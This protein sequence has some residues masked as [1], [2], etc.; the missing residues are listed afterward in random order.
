MPDATSLSRMMVYFSG[1][2]LFK[3]DLIFFCF[4][5]S[6]GFSEI[7]FPR[8]T[9]ELTLRLRLS[10][11]PFGFCSAWQFATTEGEPGCKVY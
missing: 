5:S 11:L 7:S 4:A 1:V 9:Q 3:R 2:I 10:R 8:C 6:S